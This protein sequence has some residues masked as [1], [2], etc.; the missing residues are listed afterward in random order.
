MSVNEVILLPIAIELLPPTVVL[1]P[2]AIELLPAT[3]ALLPT[4]ILF[5]LVVAEK[6]PI[7]TE[8]LPLA[9][10]GEPIAIPPLSKAIV[11]VV[12]SFPLL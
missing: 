2:I 3:L 8:E 11:F 1:L 10:L 7:A 4:A 12:I 5:C 6:G 9:T